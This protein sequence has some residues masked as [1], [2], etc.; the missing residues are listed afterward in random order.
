MVIES[1]FFW[2]DEQK[3]FAKD[4]DA[5]VNSHVQDSEEAYWAKRFPYKVMEKVADKGYMGAGVPKE[6]GGLDLGAIG[7]CIVAEG[8]GRLY[9]VGHVFVVS[10]LGGLHQLLV[11]GTESQK[12]KYLTQIAEGK[13]MGAVCITEPFAGSDA[14]NVYTT[15]EKDGDKWV[16]NGKK[17]MITAAGVAGRYFVYVKTSD[18][19]EDR[20]Q[21][22]HITAFVIDRGIKGF[23][24]EKINALVGFDN[25]PNGYLDFDN[26]EISDEQRVG[27]VGQGWQVMMSGLNF[28][29]LI[30]AAVVGG[31]LA[32]IIK[33]TN[34]YMERRVQF[35]SQVKRFTNL[36]FDF[37][38]I[39]KKYYISRLI[40][41]YSAYLLDHNKELKL[42]EFET[43]TWASIAKIYNTESAREVGLAAVQITGGDGLCRFYPI[44]RLVREAKIGEIVAG[45]TEVQKMIIYRMSLQ[46]RGFLDLKQRFKIHPEMGVP[47]ATS[48]PS[49]WEGKDVNEENI[50]KILA[51]DFKC[52]PGLYMT[53][54]DIK[55]NLKGS[56]KK[57]LEALEEL[58]KKDLIVT[59][60]H[61]KSQKLLLAKA[62]Y[63]GLR[64][65]YPKEFYRW[66]P[67][68]VKEDE[69]M[70][71]MTKF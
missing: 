21:Y 37:A 42:T 30:G 6:Y 11:F 19:P 9:A 49:P 71:E 4:V 62:N 14:A 52:N 44:E 2:T 55:N 39:I 26:V 22:R 7:S 60:R 54:D 41:Y 5:F 57:I 12:K 63:D 24:L 20:R 64:K 70:M 15:A 47:I 13:V 61:P 53:P 46:K 23:T 3:E 67:D 29:R 32:D 10:M 69:F 43:G 66:F 65:A 1:F 40:S 8:L 27:E 59:L 34:H 33:L 51:E 45:T 31:G 25:V 28:E 35:R 17:R 50:L 68:W 36:Q 18:D 56:R 16:I 38:D 48:E 58:E